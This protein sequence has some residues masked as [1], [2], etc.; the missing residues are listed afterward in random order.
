MWTSDFHSIFLLNQ[1]KTRFRHLRRQG[2]RPLF[3]IHYEYLITQQRVKW[4][5]RQGAP[6]SSDVRYARMR[7]DVVTDE[8]S[9][10]SGGEITPAGEVLRGRARFRRAAPRVLCGARPRP[11]RPI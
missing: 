1:Y 4:P 6:C 5:R 3:R 7:S 8:S 2:T 11:P 10:I 9:G